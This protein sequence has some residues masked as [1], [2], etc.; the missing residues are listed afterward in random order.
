[1]GA[2]AAAA[3][4]APGRALP[5]ENPS[6]SLSL[7]LARKS[8]SLHA[9]TRS[10]LLRTA[11]TAHHPQ[12][13]VRVRVV[14]G[15]E[16]SSS[17]VLGRKDPGR[18]RSR[19]YQR[20]ALDST[21]TGLEAWADGIAGVAPSAGSPQAAGAS[22]RFAVVARARDCESLP[23][24]PRLVD[25]TSLFALPSESCSSGVRVRVRPRARARFF[26]FQRARASPQSDFPPLSKS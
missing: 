21:P 10:Q 25:F 1:M 5:R 26:A 7:S 3:A 18:R 23:P 2:G 4:G 20:E 14:F 15:V 11:P 9:L 16:R 17:F 19:T 22:R 13:L 8:L 6:L 12:S 24:C